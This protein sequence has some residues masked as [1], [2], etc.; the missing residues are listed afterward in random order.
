MSNF[1]PGEI[2]G[3]VIK[4]LVRNED[5]RGWLIEL[6]RKDMIEDG[7]FPQMSYISLTNPGIA[8]GPHEHLDQT[9]YFCFTGSSTFKL[10]LWDNRKDSATYKNKMVLNTGEND[11]KMVIVPPGIVH[12]YKNTGD[13]PGLVINLP[14]RLYAGRGKKEK[15]DE[16]RYEDD[17]NSPFK[18]D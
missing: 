17:Q 11:L 16:I 8:R 6:F 2:N 12:A 3:I 9:D 10:V 4:D 5:D 1:K 14:N 18:V 15:V 7:I 13:K